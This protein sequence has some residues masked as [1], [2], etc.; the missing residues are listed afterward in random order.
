MFPNRNRSG[1]RFH[2]NVIEESYLR[3]R[4]SIGM[5]FRQSRLHRRGENTDTETTETGRVDVPSTSGAGSDGVAINDASRCDRGQPS[6]GLGPSSPRSFSPSASP[7]SVQQSHRLRYVFEDGET[8]SRRRRSASP[9][10]TPS[11]ASVRGLHSGVSMSRPSHLPMKGEPFCDCHEKREEHKCVCGEE[12]TMFDWIWD[13]ENKSTASILS[14][15]SREVKFHPD[16]SSGTA[17]VRG[18]KVMKEGQHYWEVKMVTP[19]YGTDMMI[20]VGT[21]DVDMNAYHHM[22]CSLLGSHSNSWGISYTGHAYHKGTA[23]RYTNKFGQGTIIGVHLDMWRG[24]LQYY[25]NR[26]PLGVAFEGLAGKSLYPMVCSTAARSGMRLIRSWSFRTSLQHMCCSVLR[27]HLPMHQN[28][29]DALLLPPGLKA[30]LKNNMAW[31]LWPN[32]GGEVRPEPKKVK[33]RQRSEDSDSDLVLKTDSFDV[34]RITKRRRTEEESDS[35]SMN[36]WDVS[37]GGEDSES[38]APMPSTSFTGD[39]V[40]EQ[41]TSARDGSD[42]YVA[43]SVHGLSITTSTNTR[44]CNGQ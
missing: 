38:P 30:F 10:P 43:T 35:D 44:A 36:D 31:L 32:T 4:G 21:G 23:I 12:D 19:V 24:T 9:A 20:G 15:D 3:L 14:D 7:L 28:V 37:D 29:T 25:M 40:N 11:R 39:V 17:A 8:E 1:R 2:R 22:F 41:S 26:R 42:V 33:I 18:T 13:E 16:F 34:H 27:K 5:V 6:A